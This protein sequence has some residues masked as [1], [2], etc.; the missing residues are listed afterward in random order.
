[1]AEGEKDGEA[2]PEAE[3]RGS[4]VNR[5][6][7]WVNDSVTGEW[8]EL[9]DAIPNTINLARK[10]KKIFTGDLEAEVITNPHFDKKEKDLLRAQIARITQMTSIVPKGYYRKQEENERDVMEVPEEEKKSPTFEEL[11]HLENWCHFIPN[12]LKV[13]YSFKYSVEE[14]YINNLNLQ[15]KSHLVMILQLH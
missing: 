10:F 5:F 8:I 14:L 13:V 12:I 6:V 1:V 9:P 4:G 15:K 2:P 7:Y 11:T 3:P